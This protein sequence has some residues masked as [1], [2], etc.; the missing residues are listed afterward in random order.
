MLALGAVA[1]ERIVGVDLAKL[2]EAFL[3]V[4]ARCVASR[5]ASSFAVT[6]VC[7]SA[8]TSAAVSSCGFEIVGKIGQILAL[9]GV[10][11]SQQSR[12][13]LPAGS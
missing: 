10:K 1:F 4:A 7:R 11:L 13:I 5:A 12:E 8:S 3:G 2:G 6:C 9:G